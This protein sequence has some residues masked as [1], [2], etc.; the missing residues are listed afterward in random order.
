MI[1]NRNVFLLVML[2]MVSSLYAQES[3]INLSGTVRMP[4]GEPIKGV[5]VAVVNESKSA[6]TNKN[7]EFLLKKIQPNDLIEVIFQKKRVAA[8]PLNGNR[9]VRIDLLDNH[10][11]VLFGNGNDEMFALFEVPKKANIQSDVV[12]AEMIEKSGANTLTEIIR[13]FIPS[14]QFITTSGGVVPNF[15]GISSINNVNGALILVNGVDMAFSTAET[16][17]S[18][19]DIA[20]IE[21]VKD[22]AGYGVRG[23]S[24]VIL[25]KT[26]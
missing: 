14:V 5:V 25:I 17:I 26:K 20:T 10:I 21:A 19:H 15:R 11:R 16:S 6:K 1:M 9:Q 22:G 24:G 23:A 12:T 7:G 3:T 18:K 2:L 13:R 4:K 8:F